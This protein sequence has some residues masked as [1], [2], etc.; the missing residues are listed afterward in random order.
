MSN[1]FIDSIKVLS[2]SQVGLTSSWEGIAPVKRS[3]K[4]LLDLSYFKPLLMLIACLYLF[5]L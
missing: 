1:H 2:V 3:L 4:S 5:L